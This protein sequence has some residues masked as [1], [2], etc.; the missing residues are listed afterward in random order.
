MQIPP[1]QTPVD[2]P[3]ASMH[4]YDGE[5]FHVTRQL[6]SGSGAAE[7]H[8]HERME[9]GY[10]YAGSGIFFIRDEAYPFSAGDISLVYP[11]EKH[12][13]R[14]VL[15]NTRWRFIYPDTFALYREYP[16]R[17]QI[18]LLVN[19]GQFPGHLCARKEHK[20]LLPYVQQIIHIYSDPEPLNS[21]IP[22]LTSLLSCLLFETKRLQSLEKVGS[23][24]SNASLP[25]SQEIQP[26]VMYMLSHYTEQFPITVLSSLCYISDCHLRRSFSAVYGISPSEFLHKLRIKHTC[27]VLSTSKDSVLSVAG[28][29]GYTS[30]S[31]FNR[32]FR[33]FMHMSPMEYRKNYN[34]WMLHG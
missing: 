4:A 32:Q 8:C 34:N 14:S 22:Y 25:L 23:T 33:K 15:D 28:Q 1:R 13:T 6:V 2:I 30:V 11:W 26:A 12:D 29:C 27:G 18:D 5:D 21:K 10:C 7:L 9:I 16:F 19:G 17:E 20:I 24:Y 3:L 31:S